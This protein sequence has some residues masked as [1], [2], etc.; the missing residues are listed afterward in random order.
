MNSV[1][2][3][4]NICK[5]RKIAISKLEKD[6]GYGNGYISQLRKGI[7][8]A[9]RLMEICEYLHV[10]PEYILTGKEKSTPVENNM[11]AENVNIIRIASRNGVFQ[12][13]RLTD[14]QLAALKAI[15]DQMPDAP[16]DL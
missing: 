16:D 6:L 13:R 4:K 2:R 1:E 3:V 11:R 14:Q 10:S 12:E 9:D 15:L 5:E 7:F 8:P